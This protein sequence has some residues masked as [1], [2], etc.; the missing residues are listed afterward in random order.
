MG[1]ERFRTALLENFHVTHAW[2]PSG[3]VLEPHIHERATFAVMLEGSFDLSFRAHSYPCSP[4]TVFT[5]PAGERHGNRIGRLGARVLV[6]QPDPGGTELLRPCHDVLE[7]VHHYPHPGIAG[8][9]RR[10]VRDLEAPDALTPLPLE[11]LALDMLTTAAR[12]D[13]ADRARGQAPPWLE[14]AREMVHARFRDNLR[15]ADVAEAVDVH[16]TRLARG[17]RTH[18]RLPLG[19]YMRRLRLDWAAGRLADSTDS[20][21]SIAL[22]TGFSDQSHFTRAFKRYSGQTPQEFRTAGWNVHILQHPLPPA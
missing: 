4:A 2:F 10:A 7:R 6:V 20:L 21:A 15:I 16:P 9:A 12:R 19:T 1:S 14:R 11:A 8:F 5:E 18:Y 3:T 17:F 22:Q 13:A